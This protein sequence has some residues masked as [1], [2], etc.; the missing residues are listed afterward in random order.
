MRIGI[1]CRLS[2]PRHAGIGRYIENLISRLPKVAPDITWVYFVA[3]KAQAVAVASLPNV[4]VIHT[5]IRHYSLAEQRDMPGFY[6]NAKLDLLHVPHFNIAL[7]YTQPFVITIHDLL[8]HEYRGTQ[9]TTLTPWKYWFKY[10]AY[11]VVATQAV[12]R[13]KAILVPAQTIKTTLA[14][15]YPSTSNKIV[16]TPEGVAGDFVTTKKASKQT[17][18]DR[19]H[20]PSTKTWLIYVGSLYPHKNVSQVLKALKDLPEHHLLLV[21]ARNIFQDE[22]RALAKELGVTSQVSFLGYVPDDDLAV[23]LQECAFLLQPSLSEGFGLTGVEAMAA[24]VP[25]LASDIPIF[26]EIYGEA[27]IYFDPHSASSLV[28]AI[29]TLTSTTRQDLVKK[30]RAQAGRYSWDTMAEQTLTT[31]REAVKKKL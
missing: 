11:R 14:K 15:Y 25:V 31:Y 10:L 22:S 21:G 28:K 6:Y 4:E 18:A 12:K 9:V 20:L 1:D 8:W 26:K 24:G 13:A 19:Y 23:L 16:I 2:G 7:Q 27:A 3:D 30:G 5:P 17:L 29:T